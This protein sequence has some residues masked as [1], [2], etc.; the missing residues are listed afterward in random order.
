MASMMVAVS[1][2]ASVSDKATGL[3]TRTV[4]VGGLRTRVKSGRR[5]ERGQTSSVPHSA[6]GT[7][8]APVAA[9]SRAVPVLPC[10]TGSKKSYPRGMVPCG[11]TMTTSP[12]FNAASAARIG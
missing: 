7:T 1:A 11:R 6:T 2:L 5:A 8:V 3:P 10:S 4:T 9:A 12:A